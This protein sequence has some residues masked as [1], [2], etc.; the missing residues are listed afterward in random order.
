VIEPAAHDLERAEKALAN[1]LYSK[2]QV[3]AV[4]QLLVEQRHGLLAGPVSTTVKVIETDLAGQHWHFGWDP[5]QQLWH[6][7]EI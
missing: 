1:G 4:A 6:K 3:K 7:Q 2:E 5:V